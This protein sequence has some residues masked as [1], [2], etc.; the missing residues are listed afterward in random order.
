MV[1]R[2][3]V[4]PE[5]LEPPLSPAAAV[6]LP[7]TAALAAGATAFEVTD[8]VAGDNVAPMCAASEPA[9]SVQ[10]VSTTFFFAFRSAVL[11]AAAA[12]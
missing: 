4:R 10:P 1:P 11:W 12:F 3:L 5:V 7:A 2:V 9:P 6:V 8:A